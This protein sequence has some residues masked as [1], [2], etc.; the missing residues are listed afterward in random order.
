LPELRRSWSPLFIC[1][2][3]RK[4]QKS[5]PSTR[6]CHRLPENQ[7][8]PSRHQ[9]EGVPERRHHQPRLL[10]ATMFINVVDYVPLL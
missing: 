10:H 9:A 2:G 3:R 6:V 5:S 8:E 1:H 4:K 7:R